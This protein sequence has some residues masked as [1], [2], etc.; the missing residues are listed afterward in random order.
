MISGIL[1]TVDFATRTNAELARLGVPAHA[2]THERQRR[3]GHVRRISPAWAGTIGMWGGVRSMRS[4]A[5]ELEMPVATVHSWAMYRGLRTRTKRYQRTQAQLAVRALAL[6]GSAKVVAQAMGLLPVETCMYRAAGECLRTELGVTLREILEWPVER[7]E[8]A[9]SSLELVVES[10]APTVNVHNPAE[11]EALV[12]EA[13]R[14][15]SGPSMIERQ[16]ALVRRE[17]PTESLV[18]RGVAPPWA[19]TVSAEH[20]AVLEQLV[21]DAERAVEQEVDL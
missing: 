15:M 2:V 19:G 5:D 17:L 13:T 7:L 18:D 14:S 16:I 6:P 10:I 4:I 21:A 11:L 12:A 20:H 9:W 3:T 1:D 8:D